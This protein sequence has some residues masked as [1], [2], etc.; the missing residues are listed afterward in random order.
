MA[1]SD[2]NFVNPAWPK[3]TFSFHVFFRGFSVIDLLEDA[4]SH[5]LFALKRI[6]C[7]GKSDEAVAMKEVEAMRAFKHPYII[8]LE[9]YSMITV[10]HHVESQDLITEMLLVMPFYRV[11]GLT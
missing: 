10:G 8:S 5:K 2:E 3:V 6:T 11:G 4:H 7:H 1:D 9:E